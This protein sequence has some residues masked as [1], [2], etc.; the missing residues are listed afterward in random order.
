[1]PNNM[2]IE[3]QSVNMVRVICGDMR[4]YFILMICAY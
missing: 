3:Q 2:E 4:S 1:M